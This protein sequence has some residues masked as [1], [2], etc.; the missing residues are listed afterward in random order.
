MAGYL[1]QLASHRVGAGFT[2]EDSGN[3]VVVG[4]LKR[5][6]R[7]FGPAW[8]NQNGACVLDPDERKP[9]RIGTQATPAKDRLMPLTAGVDKDRRHRRLSAMNKANLF[10]LNPM[11][12]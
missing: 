4:I 12:F 10:G 11:P 5:G 9:A 6:D 2:V 1:D 7:S 3:S 8:V